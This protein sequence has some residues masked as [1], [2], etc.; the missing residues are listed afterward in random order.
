MSKLEPKNINKALKDEFWI[1]TM[2]EELS[3]F[4]RNQVWELVPRPLDTNVIGTK[5]IF[6]NKSDESGNVIRNK[7][8]LVSQG[9]T[10]VEG[11]VL[12]RH[13]HPYLY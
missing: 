6:R 7:A 10:Q 8:R 2:Q 1:G 13:L 3:Q 11:I 4:E 5:C 12:R 9:Y